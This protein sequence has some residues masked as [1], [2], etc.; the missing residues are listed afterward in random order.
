MITVIGGGPAGAAASLMLARLGHDVELITKAGREQTLVVSLPPSCAK[1]FDA[2][3]L[4]E[5]IDRA[6]FIR[7]TGNTVWWGGSG[8]RVEA[9][10]GDARGWQLDVGRLSA[11]I[12]KQAIAAGARHQH[13]MVVDVPRGFV[14][15][16]SGRSGVIARA[17]HVRRQDEARTVA[18]VGEWRRKTSW[19]VPDETH[20]LIESYDDGWMWSVPGGDG[21]RHVAAMVDPQRSDLA[22]TGSAKQVYLAEIRK[23][24][25]FRDLVAEAS[26]EDGPW[27]W[28]ATQYHAI[29]YAGDDWLLVGDAGSF[30]DPL[31]SAGVKK[32]LASAWL[33]AIT[34]NTCMKSP[35]MRAHAVAFFDAREREIA[36]HLAR[37]SRRF[38]ADA[39]GS[40]RHA[41]WE[42]RTDVP[43]VEIGERDA[44]RQASERLR[45]E[46]G[47]CAAR[48]EAVS[49]EHR[50]C[51][52]A[53]EI[54]LEP[55]VVTDDHPRGIRHVCGIN[56][57]ALIELAPAASDVPQLYETY[58]DTVGPAPLHDFLFALATAIARRWLVSEWP[59][60]KSRATANSVTAAER[61]EGSE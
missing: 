16:C 35:S 17:R 46:D 1:L 54:V 26:L 44:V 47:F 8:A 10:A 49:I 14:L 24:R 19:A 23:T 25:V 34:V 38:L 7:S 18:L 4:T 5:D 40:H 20:T 55:H 60:K 9:F 45:T 27:G 29:A 48:A 36:T 3:G 22:R 42:D 15:D 2:L 56:V 58:V 37:E 33:A 52:R 50:P 21:V 61:T 6:G 11:I 28:D 41:F 12:T 59:Q 39:A 13:R 51:I 43:P 32:A 57:V 53:D 31:S 30:I